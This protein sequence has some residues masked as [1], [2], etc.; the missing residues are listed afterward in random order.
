VI[1]DGIQHVKPGA[2]VDPTEAAALIPR[3]ISA[4]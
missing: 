2:A 1:V 4:N 3:Q